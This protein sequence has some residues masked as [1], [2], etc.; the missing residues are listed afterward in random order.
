MNKN[1]IFSGIIWQVL[2]DALPCTTILD[3][4][5]FKSHDNK[6]DLISCMFVYQKLEDSRS[7]EKDN[8]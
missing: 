7:S 5:E 2:Y 3:R 8:Y 1:S 4:E 6:T